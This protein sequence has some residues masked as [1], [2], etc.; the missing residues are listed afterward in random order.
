MLNYLKKFAVDIFPSVAATVIGAYIVNHYIV[1]RPS[2]DAP[3][4]AAASTADPKGDAKA[5]SK[6][7]T[8]PV[9]TTASVSNLPAAGV[10]AKG[11]SEKAIMEKTAAER[12]AVAE[13]AQGKAE[14]KADEKADSKPVDTKSAD[15]KPVEPK[16]EKIRVILPSP[17][18]PLQS[19][20]AAAAPAPAAP[21]AVTAPVAPVEAAAVAPAPAAPEERRDANDL[22]RAAIE[23]LRANGD[24]PR[25]PEVARVHEQ[26]KE[27]QPKEA[28]RVANAPAVAHAPVPP[29]A[30]RP[31]P[32][33]IMVSGPSVN[34]PL[35][36]VSSQPRPPYAEV[37]NPNRP[38][39][40]ADIPLSRPLDLRADMTEPS[41]R[42]RATAAAED[43]LS[44]AKSIFHAVLPK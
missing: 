4:A 14:A 35:G 43:A 2:S 7:N 23:R 34:E 19:S 38:V 6:P 24:A 1:A 3:P 16:T 26:P 18:Q 25:A 32:P 11:I 39:P 20:A 30:L 29:P 9:E 33:P 31:L 21:V 12:P 15:A 44:T 27:A 40:P 17:I 22:A 36:Q 42:E 28:P 41:V 13:K 8:K 37:A 5:E 10:K